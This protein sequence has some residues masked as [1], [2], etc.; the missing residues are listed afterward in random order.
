MDQ[1][2]RIETFRQS[3]PPDQQEA[4]DAL[5]PQDKDAL[6]VPGSLHAQRR[7][8]SG[9]RAEKSAPVKLPSFPAPPTLPEAFLDE[10]DAH[11]LATFIRIKREGQREMAAWVAGCC[12]YIGSFLDQNARNPAADLTKCHLNRRNIEACAK[13]LYLSAIVDGDQHSLRYFVQFSAE[14]TASFYP[15]DISNFPRGTS[16]VQTLRSYLEAERQRQ[17]PDRWI[18]D[19]KE[20][21]RLEE[22]EA[23]EKREQAKQNAASLRS[24]EPAPAPP[25]PPSRGG[26]AGCLS[27]TL[28]LL[29]A[30]AVLAFL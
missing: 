20:T 5:S 17:R 27:M 29:A 12:Q 26:K 19:W 16:D 8:S 15:L 14:I 1:E 4:F 22:R 24:A 23:L 9:G 21:Y 11:P 30:A 10:L 13:L 2:Q 7:A 28:A 6:S 25:V 3:L 18:E